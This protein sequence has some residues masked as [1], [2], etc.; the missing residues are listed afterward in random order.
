[1]QRQ[2]CLSDLART[3][4]QTRPTVAAAPTAA[5]VYVS[6]CP[7]VRRHLKPTVR[8]LSAPPLTANR[9]S[10]LSDLHQW[11]R[12]H[13]VCILQLFI[14]R[15]NTQRSTPIYASCSVNKE[16]NILF[17]ETPGGPP[18]ELYLV[19]HITIIFIRLFRILLH[20]YL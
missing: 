6:Q 11:R 13:D 19:G 9:P 18:R 20:R 17:I 14:V 4:R 16:T 15:S 8:K 2:N 5:A 10:T 12:Q 3:V 7:V 1:V